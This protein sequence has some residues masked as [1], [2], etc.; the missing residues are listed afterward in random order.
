MFM[1]YKTEAGHTLLDWGLYIPQD[2]FE[3]KERCQ[4]AH[5][6]QDTIFQKKALMAVGMFKHF[7]A[8]GGTCTFVTADEAYGRDDEFVDALEEQNQPYVL[9]IPKDTRICVGT[10]RQKRKAETWADETEKNQWMR[11]S[12]GQGTQGPRLYDW[13]LIPRTEPCSAGYARSLLVRR[14]LSDP[15][16]LAYYSCLSTQDTAPDSLVL[17]AGS[18]WSIEECFEMSK[19]ETGLDQYEVRGWDGWM[20]HITL[21]MWALFLLIILKN[22]MVDPLSMHTGLTP[23]LPPSFL[24]IPHENEKKQENKSSKTGG[25][26]DPKTPMD[27]FKKKRKIEEDQRKKSKTSHS[28]L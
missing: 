1:G 2:W 21:S 24:S 17:A 20:R 5:I 6:P 13:L 25:S 12:C 22:K 10:L 11:L 8:L 26:K 23:E 3:D 7:K 9:A 4:K 19:G 18:R 14:S 27:N 16:D 15:S 28:S